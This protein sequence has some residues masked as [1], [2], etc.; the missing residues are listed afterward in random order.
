[1]LATVGVGTVLV[2][3]VAISAGWLLAFCVSILG[4]FALSCDLLLS[5]DSSPWLCLDTSEWIL[6]SL[7]FRATPVTLTICNIVRENN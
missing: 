3:T 2:D 4:L 7:G 1:M 5:L 6:S